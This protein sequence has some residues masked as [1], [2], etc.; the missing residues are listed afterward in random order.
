MVRKKSTIHHLSDHIFCLLVKVLSKESRE[1]SGRDDGG[2][3]RS[4]GRGGGEGA[5]GRDE[6]EEIGVASAK[7][8]GEKSDDDT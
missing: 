2:R 6:E 3:E 1:M 5:S 4:R 8:A 7:G